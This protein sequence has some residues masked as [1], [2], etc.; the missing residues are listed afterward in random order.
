[1]C[2]VASRKWETAKRTTR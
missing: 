1:M 2:S